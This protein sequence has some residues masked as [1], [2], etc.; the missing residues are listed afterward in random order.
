MI[1]PFDTTEP[2]VPADEQYCAFSTEDHHV[3][4]ATDNE[5]CWL[6][7]DTTVALADAQ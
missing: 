5:D 7:S 1:Q 2:D 6:Q 4:Y 3:I